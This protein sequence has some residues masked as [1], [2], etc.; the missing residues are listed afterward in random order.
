MDKERTFEW[1]DKLVAEYSQRL[2]SYY[3]QG[4][5]NESAFEAFKKEKLKEEEKPTVYYYGS[6]DNSIDFINEKDSSSYMVTNERLAEILIAEA[7]G[8]LKI[9][10]ENWKPRTKPMTE[11][12]VIA[13]K[14]KAIINCCLIS[15]F[16]DEVNKKVY[17]QKEYLQFGQECFEAARK[18]NSEW[19]YK[20]KNFSD[21]M[22]SK[23]EEK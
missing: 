13:P 2:A 20:F 8:R 17:S 18:N 23:G 7:E 19:Y 16:E 6:T 15:P 12:E 11:Y 5:S 4:H 10:N 1:N 9:S 21:Y 22:N 3:N 14:Q